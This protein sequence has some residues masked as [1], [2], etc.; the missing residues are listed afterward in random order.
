MDMG[1]LE[2]LV[3]QPLSQCDKNAAEEV[4]EMIQL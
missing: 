2:A 3:S 4:K 1:L